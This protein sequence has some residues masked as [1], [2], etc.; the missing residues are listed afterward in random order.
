[1]YRRQGQALA[2][3]QTVHLDETVTSP[4]LPGFACLLSRF[5]EL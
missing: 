2:L 3:A 4:L 1:M 5:F